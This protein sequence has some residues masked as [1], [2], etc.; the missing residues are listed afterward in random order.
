MYFEIETYSLSDEDDDDYEDEETDDENVSSYDN[1]DCIDGDESDNENKKS[2]LGFS[3]MVTHIKEDIESSQKA[4][5]N[6]KDSAICVSDKLKTEPVEYDTLKIQFHGHEH[7]F[8]N[9][10]PTVVK[11]E[12]S[13]FIEESCGFSQVDLNSHRVKSEQ[14]VLK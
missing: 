5:Q 8:M 2:D 6:L 4:E 7:D 11:D 14:N 10:D 9:F 12:P 1:E 13:V 3:D